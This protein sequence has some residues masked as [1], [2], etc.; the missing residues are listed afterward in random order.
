MNQKFQMISE[1]VFNTAYLA[2]IW[3]LVAFMWR[4]MPR[5]EEKDLPVARLIRNGF[6][7]L[8]I[9]DTGHVGFRVI[10]FL[11]GGLE[12]NALLVGLGALATAVTVTILYMIIL[13]VWRQ[14]FGRSRG[15][16]Y[17]ALMAAGVVRLLVFF[18]PGNEWSRVVPPFEWSLY[19][20]AFLMVQ[21]IGAALLILYD[22]IRVKDRLFLWIAIMIFLSYGFYTPVILFVQ[23]VPSVGLLMIPKTL[24]YIAMAGIAYWGIFR[25]K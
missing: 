1:I 11:S 5:V 19:R 12:N 16:I 25:R 8:A 24:A 7:L 22:S 9:G 18:H 17:Y 2:V 13:E 6:L 14:R 21:G 3:S 20:N 10:A 15:V 23:K 4:K